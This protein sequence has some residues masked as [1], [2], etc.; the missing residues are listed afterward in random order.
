MRSSVCSFALLCLLL[1]P[2]A[3]RVNALKEAG[4]LG[5]QPRNGGYESLGQH[6]EEKAAQ[7]LH[8]VQAHGSF[9]A[10]V[11]IIFIAEGNALPVIT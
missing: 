6:A 7:E 5:E 8:C 10:A 2:G 9:L 4:L 11:S 3:A 1:H